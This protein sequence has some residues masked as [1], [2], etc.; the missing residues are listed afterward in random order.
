MKKRE[1]IR[2]I[3]VALDLFYEKDK[4]LIEI[5]VHERSIAHKFAEYLQLLFPDYNLDC[6]YDKRG[7]YT[8]KLEDI[9]QCAKE[10][11]TNRIL[12]DIIIHERGY[13]RNNLV[14]F[15]IKSKSGATACDIKKLELLT[16][17]SGQFRYHFGFFVRFGS[18]RAECELRLF[19]NGIEN[20]I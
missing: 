16:K 3:N 13:D 20:E 10:R 4:H 9:R 6:E 11:T 18:E 2:K 1:I 14:I 15:E 19:I 7:K 12:P 8:K 17:E 5:N